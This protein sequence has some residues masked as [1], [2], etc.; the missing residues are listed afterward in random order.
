MHRTHRLTETVLSASGLCLL[1]GGAAA[2]SD[3]VRL[4]VL[5]VVSGDR[6]ELATITAPAHRAAHAVAS[7]LADVQA[8]PQAVVAFGLGA[9]VLFILMFRT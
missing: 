3:D 9:V 4:H 2:I 6:G 5:N 7:T 8:A 1:V